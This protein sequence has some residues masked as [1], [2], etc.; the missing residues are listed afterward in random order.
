MLEGIETFTTLFH[1]LHHWLEG[2]K[3]LI[4]ETLEMDTP[5]DMFFDGTHLHSSG[6]IT[7]NQCF[8]D[9]SFF[10]RDR[11]FPLLIK[12]DTKMG[13]LVI[14]SFK[15]LEDPLLHSRDFA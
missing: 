8:H 13:P 5:M 9:T 2:D 12:V 11:F 10:M 1:Q 6:E 15:S 3:I 4:G 14:S 7:K